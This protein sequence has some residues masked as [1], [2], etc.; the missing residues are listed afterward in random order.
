MIQTLH[1]I[2]RQMP[3]QGAQVVV[4]LLDRIAARNGDGDLGLGYD[5][6]Q[7]HLRD[8]LDAA[9]DPISDREKMA[10]KC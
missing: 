3:T 7:R 1:L 8:R 6:I 2:F 5:P 4:E 9:T 10:K